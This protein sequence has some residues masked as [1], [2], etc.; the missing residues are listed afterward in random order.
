MNAGAATSPHRFNP[1]HRIVG[2]IVLVAVAVVFLPMVL[3]GGR[4]TGSAEDPTVEIPEQDRKVFVSRIQPLDAGAEAARDEAAAPGQTAPPPAAE[5]APSQVEP[6]KPKPRAV[7]PAPAA[8]AADSAAAGGEGWA[9]R[10]GTFAHD[11]NVERVMTAVKKAGFTPKSDEITVGGENATRI[12][13]GPYVDKA[14]A[15][16][17]LA[18]INKSTGEKGLIVAYPW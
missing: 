6:V 17:A 13:V 18:R 3:D 1:K 7:A 12:W 4:G 11:A 5:P 15:E 14:A 16:K 9:V 8:S 10:I 2:A